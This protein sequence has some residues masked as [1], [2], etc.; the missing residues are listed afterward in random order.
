M[1]HIVSFSGG[2]DSTAM[3]LMML[4]KNMP[5]DEIIYFDLGKEFPEMIT[6]IEKVENYIN[7]KIT[8][9]L[10]PKNFTYWF[11]KH[12][13]TKGKYKN[14]NGYFW[15]SFQNRWC[16]RLKIE[17]I[18]KYLKSKYLN[19]VEYIGY[20]FDEKSR[21]IKLS[22]NNNNKKYPLIEWKI[23]EKQALEYC[24][25]KGFFWNGLYK[26]F[27]R[28]SC[29]LCPLANISKLRILYFDFPNLWEDMRQLDKLSKN[30]FRPDYSLTELEIK[31]EIEKMQIDLIA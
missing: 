30:K 29:Y 13:K 26:K 14:Q 17:T 9:L 16:T 23:T 8:K 7:R 6:H 22:T 31:F 24:Y 27:N 4:E 20:S 25:K 19:Y 15:M 2:K 18:K 1:K 10:I 28:V 12:K 3:L 11:Y 5:V 21:A